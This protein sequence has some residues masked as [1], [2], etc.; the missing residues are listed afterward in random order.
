MNVHVPLR[1]R[2]GNPSPPKRKIPYRSC[3]DAREQQREGESPEI[4]RSQ[5]GC[6][7]QASKTERPP[8]A[9]L[10]TVSGIAMGSRV[11]LLSCKTICKLYHLLSCL[12]NDTEIPEGHSRSR[13]RTTSTC[14]TLNTLENA[15][16][17]RKCL[18]LRG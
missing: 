2:N 7:E 11:L 5:R 10:H 18:N 4:K 15:P 6:P 1:R 17:R 13:L 16:R 14:Y 8:S 9:Y 3:Q 12:R